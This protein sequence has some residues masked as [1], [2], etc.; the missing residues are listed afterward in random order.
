M[1]NGIDERANLIALDLVALQHDGA[2]RS[3]ADPEARFYATVLA[4]FD[5]RYAGKA[6]L[7]ETLDDPLP[8]TKLRPLLP[9]ND[10]SEV[11]RPRKFGSRTRE[12]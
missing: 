12:T 6:A 1:S 4:R 2:I 3:A 5:G 8:S 9:S 7:E 11:A 10:H